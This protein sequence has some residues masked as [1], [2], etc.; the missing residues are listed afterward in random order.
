MISAA[1]LVAEETTSFDYIIV[2]A[3]AAGSVL[4]A[5]LTE[6]PE[7]KVLVLEAGGRD[8]DERIYQPA[9]FRQLIKSPFDWD[10]RT[11]KEP[12]LGDRSVSWPRGKV[13]G[14]SGSI[15]AMVY[16]R[17]HR[18]DFDAWE[19]GGNEGWG[20]DDVLLYF[21]KAENQERGPS[22]YHGVGGPQNVADP[23]WVPPIS[24]AF[25]DAA[26]EAGIPR[27]EDFNG[28][29]QEGAGLYQLNQKNGERHSSAAAYLR[30]ALRRENLTVES[31]A[32]ATR[33]LFDRRR[34]VGVSYIQDGQSHEV[35]AKR[36]V[37]LSAGT[38]GS[39][40]LLMLSGIGPAEHLK[41]LDIALLQDLPGVGMNLRDHPRV[42]LTY[43]SKQ[44]LAFDEDSAVREYY[45]ERKGPLSGNGVGAGAFVKVPEDR[46]SPNIQIFLTANP[47]QNTFSLNVALMP[48]ESQGRIRL[49]SKDPTDYPLIHANY[50]AERQDLEGLV[51]G[52]AVAR[53]IA[54]APVLE[55]YRGQ[56]LRPGPEMSEGEA[57]ERYIR[58]NLTTFF[59]AI[60]TCKMGSDPLAVVDDELRVHGVEG[61]RVVDA[62]IMPTLIS[63]ATHAATVMI[64]EKGADIIK[65]GW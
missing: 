26:S 41:A 33:V 59:H 10:Y 25:L 13:W 2:G 36:E 28:E 3:G 21:K 62:S 42:A 8:D 55:A 24:L 45:L 40:Q 9:A 60:G 32:L 49:R 58:E 61:L 5:R 1:S 22:K 54:E 23:R 17:G 43:E 44:T 56:E 39:P 19:E 31:H 52:L 35:R 14:G 7:V 38:I 12:L 51:A 29:K 50:L 64:A 18:R 57:L 46:T 6:N 47:V 30:P 48:P 63:G 53:R 65:E 20:F 11:E 27:N 37:V 15:T 16:V 34:A 4:A